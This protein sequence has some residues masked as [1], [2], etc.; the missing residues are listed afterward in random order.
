MNV[1]VIVTLCCPLA[2]YFC[3]AETYPTHTEP[4]GGGAMA[5]RPALYE[6]L[7]VSVR[8]AVVGLP[9]GAVVGAVVEIVGGAATPAGMRYPTSS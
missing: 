3:V 9:S 7:C 4:A 5:A 2:A 6:A 8:V 1:G